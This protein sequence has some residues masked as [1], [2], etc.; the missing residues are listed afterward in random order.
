MSDQ[1]SD[2]RRSLRNRAR[3]RFDNLLSRGTWAPL[4]LLG[5]VTLVVVL[6]SSALLTVFRVT[7][8]GS[9]DASWLEDF[10]QSLLRA[11]DPG[12]MAADVGWGRRLLALLVT[13]VGILIAGTLIGLIAS[14]VE[15]RVEAMRRG[16]SVVVESGHVVILGASPRLPVIVQQLAIAHQGRRANAIVV[17]ADREPTELMEDV[18]ALAG[19]L[20]G[21]RLVFRRGDPARGSDL[22]LVGVHEARAVIVLADE[23]GQGDAG[24]VKAVLAVGAE[25]GGFDRMPIVAELSD[26]E[27]A[28]SVVGA[29][30]GAVHPIVTTQAMAR[31]AAF[32]LREPGLSQVVEQ[33]FDYRG[34]AIYV[35]K[36]G[37]VT[38]I[39]FGDSVF[40]FAKA[41]PVGRI[42]SDGEVDINP[43][44]HASLEESDRLIVIADDD[45][46]PA[47]A[48]DDFSPGVVAS[49][50]P[51]PPP[52]AGAREEHLLISGWNTL[53]AQLL[54][55]LGQSAAPGSS[56]E[57]VYDSR[58]FDSE[59]P[60]VPKTGGLRV[61]LTPTTTDTWQLGDEART[62]HITS[63]VLLGYRRG[64][65][66]Q[67]ADSRTL[68]N[69]MLL[70]RE[71]EARGG[72]L[73]RIVVEVLDAENADLARTTG[74]DDYL[75]SDGISSRLITQLAEQPERRAVLLS[76][77]AADGPSIHLV[78]AADL[79]LSGEVGSDKIIATAYSAGLLAIG[80]RYASERGGEVVLNP[81]SSERVHLEDGDQIVVIG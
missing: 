6:V 33:L 53:G 52:N 55:H 58:L 44:P 42:R 34:C 79:G 71:L 5:V 26:L 69:L 21:S 54:T 62:S 11:M 49:T 10:W 8:S 32:A 29:S 74:A 16:R 45:E 13:T 57:V 64:M 51:R 67:E 41:R 23:N 3:Y 1:R 36:P 47:L 43:D 38:G 17:L 4:L 25:L 70:R 12:T 76:L 65:S 24:V 68:L 78:Q 37:A 7:F 15:Q 28:E 31:I 66:P 46:I 63:I 80:W 61:T 75:V 56:A 77:F 35:R 30:G 20:W 48:P 72:V 22:A 27:T 59:E 39:S 50:K 60:D 2:G 9:E 18:R 73:P 81:D 14:G 40:R 19:N